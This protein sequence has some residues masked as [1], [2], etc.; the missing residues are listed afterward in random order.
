[1]FKFLC[2][3]VVASLLAFIVEPQHAGG[4]SALPGDGAG[5]I[6]HASPDA[7]DAPFAVPITIGLCSSF[8]SV[9][10]CTLICVTVSP[11]TMDVTFTE[12][13]GTVYT[14][15]NV[16]TFTPFGGHV[17]GRVTT[18]QC[19]YTGTEWIGVRTA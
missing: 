7:V 16:G 6:E 18:W 3:L 4:A 14:Y 11:S 10:T 15:A 12:S 1:M 19:W 5:G 17:V 8:P 9:K 2:G 13:N